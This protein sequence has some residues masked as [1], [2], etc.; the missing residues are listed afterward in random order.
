MVTYVLEWI[1]SPTKGILDESVCTIDP[2][3]ED[4]FL[5]IKKARCIIYEG[6]NNLSIAY[7]KTQFR[8]VS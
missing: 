5:R 8:P 6:M 2:L 1:G 4:P 3:K 7:S